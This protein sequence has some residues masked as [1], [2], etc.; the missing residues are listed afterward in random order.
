M[1]LILNRIKYYTLTI[2]LIVIFQS[3]NTTSFSENEL[4][5]ISNIQSEI[6]IEDGS[7][8]NSLNKLK[9]LNKI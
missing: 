3:C 4:K 2:I 1:T 5:N 9:L 6:S 7:K 8:Q